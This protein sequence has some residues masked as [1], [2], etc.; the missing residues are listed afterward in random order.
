VPKGSVVPSSAEPQ[1]QTPTQQSTTGA[2]TPAEQKAAVEQK[3]VA[4]HD[5]PPAQPATTVSPSH[6]VV[7]DTLIFT[8]ATILAGLAF[9]VFMLMRQRLVRFARK[10]LFGRRLRTIWHQTKTKLLQTRSKVS[11]R[12]R[13]IF[14]R[15]GM[16]APLVP[17][18]VTMGRPYFGRREHEMPRHRYEHQIK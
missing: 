12:E 10:G 11:D 14:G 7:E 3:D 15:K 13:T 9:F 6:P 1:S 17:E 5:A 2:Q 8:A 18:Q 16:Q 4:S